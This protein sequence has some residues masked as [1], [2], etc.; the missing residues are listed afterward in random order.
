M[1][2]DAAIV[3][4]RSSKSYSVA[5][6]EVSGQV[7]KSR[8]GSYDFSCG[9]NDADFAF[10]P[11]TSDQNGFWRTQTSRNARASHYSCSVYVVLLFRA[12]ANRGGGRAGEIYKLTGQQMDRKTNRFQKLHPSKVPNKSVYTLGRVTIALPRPPARTCHLGAALG[13]QKK[14]KNKSSK[15]KRSDVETYIDASTPKRKCFIEINKLYFD[16]LA[17]GIKSRNVTIVIGFQ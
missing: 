4:M 1:R 17:R 7:S 5:L 2:P 15:S 13:E 12:R 9:K 14:K 8:G 16:I 10:K 11:K 3:R 6:C